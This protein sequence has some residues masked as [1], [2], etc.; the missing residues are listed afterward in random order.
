MGSERPARRRETQRR[1]SRRRGSLLGRFELAATTLSCLA[2]LFSCS[3]APEATGEVSTVGRQA[4]RDIDHGTEALHRGRADDARAFFENALRR[5]R[6]LDHRT[7]IAGTLAA[8]GRLYTVEGD[9]ETAAVYY[10]DSAELAEIAEA[11]T[12][13]I[14]SYAALVEIELRRERTGDAEQALEAAGDILER[15]PD[16]AGTA[17]TLHARALLAAHRGDFEHA[18]ESLREALELNRELRAHREI[19][20]NHYM[21]ASVLSRQGRFEEAHEQATAALETD[22]FIENSVGIAQDLIA[23]GRIAERSGDRV[24]AQQYFERAYSVYLGLEDARGLER[25]EQHL[26]RLHRSER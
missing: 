25:V 18:E 8:I 17:V 10:R 14:E 5:Y 1:A 3:S 11:P 19:A 26:T 15:A 22:K 9:L 23:L 16:D 24:A 20:A 4:A 12:V 7:G 2:L 13:A 6:S 21:L